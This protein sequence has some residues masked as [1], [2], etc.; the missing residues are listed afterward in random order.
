MMR[1]AK[2]GLR[3]RREEDVP[4]LHSELYDDVV[5]RSRADSRPWRPIGQLADSPYAVRGPV[6]NAAEFSVIEL[7]SGRLAGEAVLWSIDTHHRNAHVGLSVLPAFRGQGL[8]TDVVRVLCRYG[9]ETLG[10]QRLQ[11]DTLADNVGMLG[12]AERAGFVREGRLRSSAWANGEF[13]DLVLLGLLASDHQPR[14][15]AR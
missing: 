5:M 15:D 13:V 12:A 4:V 6:D 10:L 8:G 9:F 3:A 2:V 1:G 11:V 7:A 14:R